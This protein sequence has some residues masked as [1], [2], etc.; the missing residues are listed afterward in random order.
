MLVKMKCSMSMRESNGFVCEPSRLWIERKGVYHYQD[1]LNMN[2][3]KGKLFFLSNWEPNFHCSH[4]ERI[5]KMGDGGKWVCDFY[6]LKSRRNCLV[7]SVGSRGEF[8][9][10][11]A[12]KT[13]LPHCEIHTFDMNYYECP[14]GICIFHQIMFGDGTTIVDSQSWNKVVQQLKHQNRQIDILKIDIEGGEYQTFPTIFQS[15]QRSIPRQILVEIHLKQ[16]NVTHALFQLLRQNRYV[17]FNKEPN[18]LKGPR[19]F[20][21]GFLRLNHQFFQYPQSHH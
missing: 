4:S 8:S 15:N 14:Q 10:E 20:E 13:R 7:Y 21:Y 1:Q 18:L 3:T 19:L 16:R 11:I 2:K 9:F 6:Q 17:I 5:G 12:L